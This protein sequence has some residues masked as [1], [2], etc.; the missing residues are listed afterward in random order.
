[1]IDQEIKDLMITNEEWESMNQPDGTG[2]D[3][4]RFENC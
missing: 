2:V 1:M 3:T 4:E